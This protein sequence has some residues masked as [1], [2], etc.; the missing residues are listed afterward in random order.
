MHVTSKCESVKVWYVC[1]TI[2]ECDVRHIIRCTDL[3]SNQKTCY[4]SL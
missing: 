1:T 4:M 2:C 3:Q